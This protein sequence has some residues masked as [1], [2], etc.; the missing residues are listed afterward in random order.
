MKKICSFILIFTLFSF[1]GYSVDNQKITSVQLADL[2]RLKK[3]VSDNLTNNILSFWSRTMVD[4]TNGGFYGR[5]DYTGK[6][7][8]DDDKGGILNARI[9]WTFSS[10]YRI[11]HS[12]VYLSLATRAKDYI[13]SHFIDNQYG[14][15]Y[16]SVTAK[17]EP[18]DTRKQ[19]YTQSFFIYGLAEYSRA[20][21]DRETLEKAMEIF[22]LFEKYALDRD[23]NGYFEVFS[24]DWHRLNDRLIGESTEMDEKTMNTHLHVMEAYANLYRVSQDKRVGERLRNLINLF[25]DKIIDKKTFHLICFFDRN[26]NGTSDIDSFG[27]DIECSWLLYE[28]ASLLNDPTLMT[29]IRETSLKIANAASEGLQKDGSL[30]TERDN[31]TGQFRTQRSWWEQA[32]TV[33]GYL[34]AFELTGNQKYL[35]NSINCWDYIKQHF[36]DNRNGAWFS[37]VLENGEPGRGDK[38]GFWVCPYHNGRMCM[39][40]MERVRD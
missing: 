13:L 23:A 4:K 19:T 14:G 21:G 28:A 34:N 38:A 31:S 37:S 35:D 10:A 9:L 26:W 5:A 40:V 24:R 25:L 11:T 32:E 22:D 2:K 6:V 18:S 36:V 1:L 3:E 33:V 17:G 20:T 16:R 12:P 15:A 27:H 7:Y 30:L 39:E 29:R 8:P